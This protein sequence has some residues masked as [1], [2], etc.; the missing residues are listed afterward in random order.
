M[1]TITED[2]RAERAGIKLETGKAIKKKLLSLPEARYAYSDPHE[3]WD[4]LLIVPTSKMHDSGYSV[5]VVVGLRHY[6]REGDYAEKIIA[7][8]DVLNL[9]A[10]AGIPGRQNHPTVGD[11]SVVKV[12]AIWPSGVLRVFSSDWEMQLDKYDQS[13]VLRERGSDQ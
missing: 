12:D 6:K 1:T 8:T 2:V 13:I 7:R 3:W 10:W 4:G 9:P 5:I 11:Y